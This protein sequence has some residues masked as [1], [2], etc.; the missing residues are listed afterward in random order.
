M[1]H[2]FRSLVWSIPL[3]AACGGQQ[4]SPP[5]SPQEAAP[6]VEPAPVVPEATPANEPA[7]VAETR[8]GALDCELFDSPKAAFER[9][10]AENPLVL[11][12]GEAHALEGT[13]GLRSTT[14][15]FTEDLFPLVA[16][17]SSDIVLELMQPDAS[18]IKTTEQVKEKQKEVTTGQA[19]SNQNEF[20][21][22]GNRAKDTGVR[23]HILYPSCEQYQ[24][25]VDAGQDFVFVS[26]ETIAMLT[27]QLAKK[28]LERND[29]Q[30]VQ[31][32]VLLYGGAVHNDAQPR[33]GR[34]RW[35]YGPSLNAY[36]KGR[37]VEVDLIVREYIKDTPPWQSL[38][39]YPHF[40]R[41]AHTDRTVLFRPAENS[42]VLIFPASPT[43]AGK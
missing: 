26:L 16:E 13:E 7:P 28:I 32:T 37:Y 42:F 27:D 35:S 3:L 12:V 18:C 25:I 20:L 2:R 23:P 21:T 41:N 15:R 33:E 6:S 9:V 38:S 14:A 22:L 43:P 5:S 29:K 17:S 11:G 10:L 34:E 30:A 39:W 19:Q 8:C 1:T 40:D 24:R 4:A 36:T 31:K